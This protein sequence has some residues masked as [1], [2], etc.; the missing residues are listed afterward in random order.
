MTDKKK[1]DTSEEVEAA[2]PVEQEALDRGDNPASLPSTTPTSTSGVTP[3]DD[4]EE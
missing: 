4:G 2:N 1:E 3:E